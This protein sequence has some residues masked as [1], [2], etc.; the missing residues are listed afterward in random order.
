ED[1]PVRVIDA[2]VDALNLGEL[3][4]SSVDPKAT[5]R[6]AYHPSVLLKLYVYG[7]HNQD[8]SSHRLEREAS[9]NVEVMWLTGQLV[10]DH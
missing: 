9:R 10:P 3:G 1:N 5:G 8:C 6:L 7:Y 4:F 2:F